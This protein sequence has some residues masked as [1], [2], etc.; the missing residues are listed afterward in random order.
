METGSTNGAPGAGAAGG[1]P[2]PEA[3]L[4]T[5]HD[6]A[7][8]HRAG[9]TE[10]QRAKWREKYRRNRD[11]KLATGGAPVGP[12]PTLPS[13]GEGIP[14]GPDP[15]LDPALLRSCLEAGLSTLNE[16]AVT[17]VTR[18]TFRVTEDRQL[19]LEIGQGV[20][21]SKPRLNLLCDTGVV[22]LQKYQLVGA[23]FPEIAFSLGLASW[24][25][26]FARVMKR[27]DEME[28]QRLLSEKAERAA[29][30]PVTPK[31]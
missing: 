3:L 23:Y 17:H 10:E 16:L 20:D 25:L 29:K 7:R 30:E 22:I 12:A 8:K 11:A 21:I 5:A 1:S 31:P 9:S 4:A 14:A 13:G 2:T 18:R 26:Q 6:V 28:A 24:G 19:A 27:L 15:V